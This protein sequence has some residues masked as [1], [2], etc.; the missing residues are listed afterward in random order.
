VSRPETLSGVVAVEQAIFTSVRSPMGQGY[1]LVVAS[2][3]V[4]T[5]EKREIVQRAPSH[6]N[7]CDPSPAG[8]GLASFAL[9]SG[10][11]CIILSQ[12][13]G[14]EQSARGGYRVHSHVLVAGVP[15]FE[16]FECNPLRIQTAARL[17]IDPQWATSPPNRLTPLA[18][19][20]GHC[21]AP[22]REVDVAA[23][24]SGAL[25]ERAERILS[26]VLS[27]RGVLVLGAT[28][29]SSVLYLLLAATP[30]SV[31]RRLSL[32]YGLKI[33]PARSFQLVFAEAGRVETERI[34][35]DQ[36]IALFR[37]DSP[38]ESEDARFEAWAHFARRHW[39][40]GR[41]GELN[42]LS[43]GLIEEHTAEALEQIATICMDTEQLEHAPTGSLDELIQKY[44]RVAPRSET[45]ARLLSEFRKVADTRRVRLAGIEQDISA[46][47][48]TRT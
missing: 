27:E 30:A 7:L 40:A 14:I 10:R 12:N 31:R 3:G 44:S 46:D 9:R 16:R 43:A 37:W 23:T 28:A 18:L 38:P 21:Q 24:P 17:A 15:E 33:S 20:T 6:G 5:D 45:H 22:C 2:P 34:V 39:A 42:R 4:A 26:A 48:I 8:A 36:D 29:P 47:N 13:A 32:S 25:I 1:R 35:R 11:R 41:T 19:T